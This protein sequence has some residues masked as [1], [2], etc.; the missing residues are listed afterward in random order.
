MSPCSPFPWT[1]RRA[2]SLVIPPQCS[3]A[4]ICAWLCCALP[5]AHAE[6]SFDVVVRAEDPA[7][8]WPSMEALLLALHERPRRRRRGLIVTLVLA[9]LGGV[10][11]GARAMLPAACE[12]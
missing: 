11:L 5:M 9:L 3:V 7:L 8:R 6:S 10:A 12:A 1:W 4:G 2:A